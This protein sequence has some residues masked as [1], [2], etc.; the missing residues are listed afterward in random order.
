MS[1]L[2]VVETILPGAYPR[3]PVSQKP[4]YHTYQDKCILK[5][6]YTVELLV[7]WSEAKQQKQHQ[8]AVDLG[9]FLFLLFFLLVYLKL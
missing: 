8:N 4:N 1:Y 2:S 7:T 6:I 9:E 3:L 5:Y